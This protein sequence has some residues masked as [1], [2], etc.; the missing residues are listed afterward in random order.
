MLLVALTIATWSSMTAGSLASPLLGD[1]MPAVSIVVSRRTSSLSP[2]TVLSWEVTDPR[3]STSYPPKEHSCSIASQTGSSCEHVSIGELQVQTSSAHG[4][5]LLS[6]ASLSALEL[7]EQ[8]KVCD[9]VRRPDPTHTPEQ[10]APGS[11]LC[12]LSSLRTVP[13]RPPPLPPGRR[14]FHP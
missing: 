4:R 2:P 7:I 14:S 12:V 3:L 11:S 13:A 10:G 6:F 1:V 5:S 8:H 9:A